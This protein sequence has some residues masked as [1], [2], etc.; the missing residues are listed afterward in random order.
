MNIFRMLGAPL[1]IVGLLAAC[2]AHP[3]D[4]N[5][6][7]GAQVEPTVK[8]APNEE[9]KRTGVVE[10]PVLDNPSVDPNESCPPLR[11]FEDL[12]DLCDRGLMP[13]RPIGYCEREQA[14]DDSEEDV[15]GFPIVQVSAF[16]GVAELVAKGYADAGGTASVT[17]YLVLRRADGYELLAEVGEFD[18]ERGYPP[19]GNR[20]EGTPSTIEL[21]T[22]Q[23][24]FEPHK[25]VA[26]T[27]SCSMDEKGEIRCGGVCP[28][29]ATIEVSP[30][31][32][33]AAIEKF[34]WARLPLGE[35]TTADWGGYWDDER[36]KIAM[37]W[38][39]AQ[40]KKSAT[41]AL[42][43][44]TED[45]DFAHVALVREVDIGSARSLTIM[46]LKSN[47]AVLLHGEVPLVASDGEIGVGQG[48][49]G[50][51]VVSYAAKLRR[52]HR[53]NIS[54]HELEPVVP[55]PCG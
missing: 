4:E 8:D 19:V 1:L 40:G 9:G 37:K 54:T 5:R 33:C 29:L 35:D 39:V 38:L 6:S 2:A 26:A 27:L 20:F 49:G 52:I 10:Q 3:S 30:P 24:F 43:S 28:T 51:F 42:R 55:G 44:M 22:T 48:P 31:L 16:G 14:V 46:K 36:L 18:P 41:K 32:D 15:Y 45:A 25:V 17:T 12:E 47:D 50:L 11:V 21:R 53:L 34:D 23:E 7:G 13:L